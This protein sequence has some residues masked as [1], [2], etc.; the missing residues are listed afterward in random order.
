M[1][2]RVIGFVVDTEDTGPILSVNR[3]KRVSLKAIATI[4][5]ERFCMIT[6]RPILERAFELSRDGSCASLGELKVRLAKDGYSNIDAHLEGPSLRKQL[7]ALIRSSRLV[8]APQ[9]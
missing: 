9:G 1:S 2:P 4:A 6:G 3:T 5:T 8:P 7:S